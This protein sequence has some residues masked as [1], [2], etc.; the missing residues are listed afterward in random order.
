MNVE[1]YV[2]FLGAD[3][4]FS[5][6]DRSRTR[7]GQDGAR[8]LR[9]TVRLAQ[10][11]ERLGYHRFW[12]SEHHGV[13]GV[14]GSAPTVLAAAV[15]GATRT[16]R[17]G[18]GGVMLPNHQP[19]VVAEQFGVLEALYP[20]R[21]DMGLGRSVGFTD[22]VRR[23][24]GREKEEAGRFAEQLDELLGWFDGTQTAHPH[25]HARPAEGL[26][27][28]PYVLATGEGAAIAAAA[29]LPLVI[30]DLRGRDRM[31]SAIDRYRAAFRPSSWAAEP[32]VVVSGTVAVART[33]AEAH[34]LLLPEAWSQAYSR[35]HGTFPP[36]LPPERIE[37]LTMTDK[38]RGFYEQGLRGHLYG[39]GD[40][41]R[42]ALEGLVKEG[43]AQE[44]LVTT[45]TYDRAALL[46]SFRLLADAV[47]LAPEGAAAGA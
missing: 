30:G 15:A 35:T 34:R 31:L 10:E 29:G 4:R 40:Q 18:T 13:P 20:G 22:G 41:V 3:I 38:E 39:T 19:L 25:V 6:L 28:P 45:S 23:A 2:S 11:V 16:I 44:V 9:D 26:R 14:A 24:L 12:V 7:E 1:P 33:E 36:L 46:D 5:V 17:V 37:A 42:E 21:I 47:G 27:V 8:A 43:G 32:Y